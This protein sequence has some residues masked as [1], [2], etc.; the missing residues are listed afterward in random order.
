MDFEINHIFLFKLFSY[1]T[2]ASRQESK[3]LDNEK[4]F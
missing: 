3:Y 4:S 1:K 2:K